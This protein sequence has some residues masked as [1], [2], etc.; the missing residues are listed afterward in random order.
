MLHC[1]TDCATFRKDKCIMIVK[2]TIERKSLI[3]C[4][5]DDVDIELIH[6]DFDDEIQFKSHLPIIYGIIKKQRRNENND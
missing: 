4:D 3:D 5:F 2:Y 1:S 6:G